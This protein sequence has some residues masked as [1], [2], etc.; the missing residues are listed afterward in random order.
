MKRQ[1]FW[2]LLSICLS[3][4]IVKITSNILIIAILFF[5]LIGL[6]Y[7]FTFKNKTLFVL[8]CLVSIFTLFRTFY[9]LY[10]FNADLNFHNKEVKLIACISSFPEKSEKYQ[11]F[12]AS[13][14]INNKEIKIR[15][16]TSLKN[17][18]LYNDLITVIGKLK[19]PT[20]KT[21]YGG[22]DYREYLKSKK[23]LYTIYSD[24]IEVLKRSQ[25][26][27]AYINLLLQKISTI[28]NNNFQKD[29]SSML[30]GII[31][32]NKNFIP[33]DIYKDFQRAG[34]AHLL[35]ASGGNIGI[36]CIFIEFL[37]IHIFKYYNRYINN[38]I[39]ILLILLY[40]ILSGFG[41][42]IVR[43]TIMAL[44]YYAG[45]IIYKNVD[46][47]NSLFLA[48]ILVL[49]INP[50]DLFNISFQLSYICVLS[51]IIFN[52]KIFNFIEK[53]IRIKSIASVISITLSSQI[54][55][56]PFLIIYFHEISI[57]S[58][59]TNIAAIILTSILIP[60]GLIY[61]IF[62][63]FGFNFYLFKFT[64]D[65][66]TNLL[67]LSSKISHLKFTYIKII[68]FD[69]IIAVVYYLIILL[70][71]NKQYRKYIL[72]LCLILAFIIS[73]GYFDNLKDLKIS[74]LDVGQGDS[75]FI[76]Y[77]GFNILIDT[78]PE[79]DDFNAVSYNIL[80][81]LFHNKIDKIDILILS[82][83][84][85]DHCGGLQDLFQNIEVKNI[86]T[87]DKTYIEKHNL[88]V[89]KNVYIVKKPLNM[90]I[91]NLNIALFPPY[92]D[93]SNGCLVSRFKLNK[94]SILFTG[95]ISM[96]S[97]EKLIYFNLK[98]TILKIAHHGS[99]TSTSQKF[100]NYIKPKFAIIS[101][102][103]DNRF[104]HPSE[105][106]TKRL[107]ENKIKIFR[108]DV[109]GEIDI[110]TDGTTLRIIPFLR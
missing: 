9:F 71:M 51:I 36:L 46:T 65:K 35:A 89:N 56:L 85:D 101:V 26:I 95:D 102:G 20:P 44:I 12:F 45:K 82:H 33:D 25:N 106:V 37:F 59:F 93:D 28:L 8:I 1:T 22:F 50:M 21:N 98:S 34:L 39:I 57:V 23:T 5:I 91:K 94:F 96:T 58:V 84:H 97:E 80:P 76:S 52:K 49:I 40:S 62:E 31:F 14:N 81:F 72:S 24:N 69:I 83:E 42:S 74:I 109:N 66:L 54:L 13:T 73:L 60:L 16:K 68:Y 48:A 17:D 7:K 90:K 47:L 99:S 18:F 67:I 29:K 63:L 11:T 53:Y 55:I 77:K 105:I 108:T 6:F 110:K 78:G 70:L 32:G 88:L 10:L 75:S 107:E 104:N 41:A 38:I 19:I 100:L 92:N 103:R 87:T 4:F 27:L 30:L 79:N 86:F 61:I 15:V 43:A 64:V 3:I 2:I